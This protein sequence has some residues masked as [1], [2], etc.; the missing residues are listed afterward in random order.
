MENYQTLT[1]EQFALIE[2][3]RK[4]ERDLWGR[5]PI[6]TDHQ[7]LDAFFYILHK[8]CRWRALPPHF[9]QWMALFMRYKRWVERGMVWKILMRLQ[10]A[11]VL[12]VT[13]AFM[14]SAVVR[15]HRHASG[16]SK[17]GGI[18]QAPGRSRNDLGTKLHLLVDEAG[19][20]VHL[21]LS[22]GRTSDHA[23]AMALIEQAASGNE[24]KTLC[25]D[26]RV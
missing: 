4:E 24:L 20:L 7:V 6:I 5:K 25:G 1:D 26:I 11:N 22:P 15:S 8:G 16:G 9:G 17:K 2:P 19:R 10:R 18:R 12:K 23:H 3:I 13:I 21:S 14:D